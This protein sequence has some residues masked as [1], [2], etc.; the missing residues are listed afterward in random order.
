MKRSRAG[1]RWTRLM[2][3][4]IVLAVLAFLAGLQ[5][6]GRQTPH[7]VHPLTGR[8]IAGIATDAQWMDR[9]SREQEEQPERA[10]DLIGITPGS[11]VADVGAGTGYM[12]TRLANLVGPSGKVYAN[13]LQPALLKIVTDKAERAWLLNIEP[14]LGTADDARL[15]ERTI[16]LVLLVDVYHEF[17]QP[18][19]MLQS[20]LRSLKPDGRLVLVEYRKEDPSIP[21][22]GTHRMSVADARTEIEAEG[23]TFEKAIEDLPRQHIIIFRSPPASVRLRREAISHPRL[24]EEV[25]R[26]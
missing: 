22:A 3:I 18:A 20:L 1:T 26:M 19:S 24:A 21:I 8:Q 5:L 6:V 17:S 2:P 14:V 25:A 10:L 13:E 16:D 23:F 9:R 15:P 12:T 4:A 11:V 7:P